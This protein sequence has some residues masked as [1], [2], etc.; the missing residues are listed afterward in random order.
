M[1]G[2]EMIR[3]ASLIILLLMIFPCNDTWAEDNKWY[4]PDLIISQTAGYVGY[5][6]LGAGYFL[7]KR[8][9]TDL[10]LG[11]VP[12]FIAGKNLFQLSWK[13]SFKILRTRRDGKFSI[14][15]FHMGIT[16]IYGFDDDFY[17]VLPE[18]YPDRYYPPTALHVAANLGMEFQYLR[19]GVFIELSASD[20][21]IEAYVNNPD[22]FTLG[23]ITTLALGYKLFL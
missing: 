1:Y 23:D 5:A 3:I 13:N 19:H 7:T 18:R 21:G 15:P 22:H 8:W 20:T 9:E 10:L 16:A 6:S 12:P 2:S 4:V 17:V 11:Y 14:S